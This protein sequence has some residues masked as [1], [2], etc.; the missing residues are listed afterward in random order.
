MITPDEAGGVKLHHQISAKDYGSSLSH[1]GFVKIVDAHADSHYNHQA[2]DVAINPALFKDMPYDIDRDLAPVA[3]VSDAPMVLATHGAVFEV[4]GMVAED[5][6]R[7]PPGA[8]AIGGYAVP[9][10]GDQA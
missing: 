6:P 10:A 8:I 2:G 5:D 7:L 1:V 3:A 9:V 4:D